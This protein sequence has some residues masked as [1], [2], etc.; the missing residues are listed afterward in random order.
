MTGNR[1]SAFDEIDNGHPM[2]RWRA[3][4]AAW[5]AVAMAQGA[6]RWLCAS[7]AL[8]TLIACA[9]WRANWAPRWLALRAGQA[10]HEAR[11]KELFELR[12][13]VAAMA[14]GR[15]QRDTLAADVSALDQAL[16]HPGPVDALLAELH[17]SAL[18]HGLR[19]SVLRTQAGTS[20]VRS[21]A[22]RARPFIQTPLIVRAHGRFPQVL[23]WLDDVAGQRG[24]VTLQRFSLRAASEG[25]LLILDAVAVA[26]GKVALLPITA[27]DETEGPARGAFVADDP[28]ATTR[29]RASRFGP[30]NLTMVGVLRDSRRRYGI[31]DDNGRIRHLQVGDGLGP[32]DGRVLTIED[33]AVSWRERSGEGAGQWIDR[34]LRM[35]AARL[36]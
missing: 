35:D 16:L 7:V 2:P 11:Q 4:L 23:A 17:R 6:M 20:P 31:V 18:R 3:R 21:S 25:G 22:G 1:M 33:D 32:R 34:T 10:E 27:D 12:T 30:D 19:L 13:R 28:F 36:H 9:G 15:R 26:H 29:L 24:A 14:A 8:G 5:S